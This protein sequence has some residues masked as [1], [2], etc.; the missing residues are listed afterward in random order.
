MKHF[1]LLLM[2]FSMV[3]IMNGLCLAN[4]EERYYNEL[5]EAPEQVR[6]VTGDVAIMGNV[7]IETSNPDYT[8][9]VEGDINFTG[10]LYQDGV[11]FSGNDEGND[12]RHSLDASDGDPIDAVYVDGSGNVGIGTTNPEVDLHLSGRFLI[13]NITDRTRKWQIVAENDTLV[14]DEWYEDNRM[15]IREGGNV[16]IGT[17]N[18]EYTLHVDGTI[19]ATNSGQVHRDYV[20]EPDYKLR[21][22]EDLEGF[23]KKEK[24]LPGVV[25]DPEKAPT[26]DIISLNGK[27][28]EKI[29]KLTLYVIKQNKELKVLK[30]EVSQ[31]KNNPAQ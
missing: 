26:V 1:L 29:E 23:I 30:E 18:P 12:N 11:E 10:D 3:F 27:L 5:E 9:D 19:G 4:E 20:F 24:H 7:G 13:D 6:T 25:T 17:K 2:M 14:F 28:L 15:V 31:L 16:G 22:L 21:S 8:L